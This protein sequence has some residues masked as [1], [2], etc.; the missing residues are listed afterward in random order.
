MSSALPLIGGVHIGARALLDINL[1]RCGHI[2]RISQFGGAGLFYSFK[3][4][5]PAFAARGRGSAP[6]AEKPLTVRR[7]YRMNCILLTVYNYTH[8]REILF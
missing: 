2:A 4:F 1:I 3:W 7:K 5:L 8:S 6:C